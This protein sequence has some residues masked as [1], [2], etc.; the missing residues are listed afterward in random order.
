M[1]LKYLI[2]TLFFISAFTMDNDN[3]I[4]VDYPVRFAYVDR[5]NGWWPP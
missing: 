4:K 2:L 1:I 3:K 5:I